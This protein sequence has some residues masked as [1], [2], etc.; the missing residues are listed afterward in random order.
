MHYLYVEPHVIV[1]SD[2]NNFLF[3]DTIANNHLQVKRDP[4]NQKIITKL[5]K[6]NSNYGIRLSKTDLQIK[7]ISC[8]IQDLKDNF[9]GDLLSLENHSSLPANFRPIA[10][11]LRSSDKVNNYSFSYGD[12]VLEHLYELNIYLNDF[13]DRSCQYCNHAYKQVRFCYKQHP[14]RSISIDALKIIFNGIKNSSIK[15]LSFLGGNILNFEYL[16]VLFDFIGTSYGSKTTFYININHVNEN[17]HVIKKIPLNIKIGLLIS[18]I[19][20]IDIIADCI[21][22]FKTMGY[23]LEVSIIVKNEKEVDLYSKLKYEFIKLLPIYTNDNIDFF[24]KNIYLE[25][26]DI[27]KTP[28]KLRHF[29]AKQFINYNFFGSLTITPSGNVF[30]SFYFKK[31]GNITIESMPEIISREFKQKLA[32]NNVRSSFPCNDCIYQFLCPSPS[33][34]EFAIGKP[35]LC[36]VKS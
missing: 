12:D 5:L 27:L 23:Q 25:E 11:F 22:Q 18:E 17:W 26:E 29:H 34:Y 1:L 2:K 15:R 4:G 16:N 6:S 30:S 7:S 36:R 13:C 28:N 3:Y 32:W 33:N 8:L 21:E 14:N 9:M 20:D 35:N 24:Q 19:Y 10:N 31:L